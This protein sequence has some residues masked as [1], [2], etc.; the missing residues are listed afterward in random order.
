VTSHWPRLATLPT[1]NAMLST[2]MLLWLATGVC[3]LVGVVVPDRWYGA[4]EMF[5]GIAVV[6]HGNKRWTNGRGVN[7]NGT[8][9]RIDG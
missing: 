7:G 1:T 8:T 2:V 5:T 6:Q 3:A 9:T 4:L